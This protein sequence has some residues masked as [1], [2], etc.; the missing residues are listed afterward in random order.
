[1][2]RS[3]MTQQGDTWDYIA[4]KLYGTEFG[5]NALLDANPQ[6]RHIVVFSAEIK[7]LVPDYKATTKSIL[8]PWRR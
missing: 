2:L 8:P 4:Y 1:M 5:M 6:F 7:L 3:Y